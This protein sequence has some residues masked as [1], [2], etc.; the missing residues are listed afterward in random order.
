MVASYGAQQVYDYAVGWAEQYDPKLA[1]ILASDP[2][3]A[4]AVFNVERARR[5]RRA[6]HRRLVGHRAGVRLLFRRAV[7]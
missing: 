5:P 6:G 7:R 4:V 2:T 1:G 3:Y